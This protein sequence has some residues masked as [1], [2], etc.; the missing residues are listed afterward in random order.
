MVFG[1]FNPLFRIIC[2]II[3]CLNKKPADRGYFC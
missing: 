3:A 1:A 2:F